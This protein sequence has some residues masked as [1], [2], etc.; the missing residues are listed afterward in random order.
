MNLKSLLISIFAICSMGL[1]ENASASGRDPTLQPYS[2]LSLWNTAIGSGAQWSYP[3][4]ADTRDLRKWQIVINA[5]LWSVPIYTASPTDHF[6]Y[7]KDTDN[8]WPVPDQY[9]R[10]PSGM[11]VAG[12]VVGGDH[13]L[14][15][16]DASKR[17]VWTYS[18]CTT[19]N[20]ALASGFQCGLAQQEDVCDVGLGPYTGGGVIRSW[21]L[22][23]GS[24]KHMLRFSLNVA[25]LRSGPTWTT[26]LQWPAIHEDY[27]GPSA[28]K[29]NLLFG[30]TIG[31]PQSV[32]LSS[33]GL[34]S[35]GLALARALQDYG[36]M[37]R[38]A[39]TCCLTFYAEAAAEGMPELNDMR[40]DSAK[41]LPYLSVLRNQS[42]STPNGGGVPRQPT[43][44]A[45]D[46]RIC[47][48][49]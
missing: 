42:P 41:L 29:G 3:Q 8:L 28:Y 32:N 18:E 35:S 9:L 38:D 1:T 44:A 46:P 37:V 21:E 26:G 7:F 4:D 15:L 25:A 24:I 33:F 30:S 20:G 49:P 40:T 6:V 17:W 36:A 47:P 14:T 34:S 22:K 11:T 45:I 10:A 31:I 13:N 43:A 5:G 23:A 48:T 16:F 39:N 12:P 2:H 27:N 19:T